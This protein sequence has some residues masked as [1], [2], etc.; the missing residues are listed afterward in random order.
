MVASVEKVINSA[1]N[2]LAI[3]WINRK[4]L[5]KLADMPVYSIPQIKKIA[6]LK[7]SYLRFVNR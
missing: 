1:T 3:A 4:H 7:N 6:T 5:G 2:M